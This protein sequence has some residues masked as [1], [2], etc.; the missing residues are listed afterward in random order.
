MVLHDRDQGV[1]V[2]DVGDPGGHLA[3]PDKSVAT[4]ELAIGG[5]PVNEPVS[6]GKVEVAT[7]RL[8]GIELHGVLGGD[9]AEVGLGSVVDV[10]VGVNVL[11][12]SSAPVPS[13]LSVKLNC[14]LKLRA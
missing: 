9:L 8:S 13:R 11:V 1:L 7:R 5:S 3:V 2:L 10:G 12:A 6:T 14:I 4:D